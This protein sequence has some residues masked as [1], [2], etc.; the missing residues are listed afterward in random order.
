MPGHSL[1]SLSAQVQRQLEALNETEPSLQAAH[2]EIL[3]K[4]ASGRARKAHVTFRDD[5]A[6]TAR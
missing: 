3:R 2:R 6:T 5:Y 1:A 4:L